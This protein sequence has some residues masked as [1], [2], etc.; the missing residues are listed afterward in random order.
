[1]LK[2]V[3]IGARISPKLDAGLARLAEL[4]GRPKSWH[5]CEA[6][7]FYVTN[8]QEFVEAVKEGLADMRAGRVL[9]H[10]QIIRHFAKRFKR[11]SHR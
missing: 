3:M 7:Q 6:I 11:T 4:T 10:E 5:L 8:E 1:M 9:K 2:S